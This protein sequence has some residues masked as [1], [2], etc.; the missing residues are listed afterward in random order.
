MPDI[1]YATVYRTLK[2]LVNVGLASERSFSENVTRFEPIHTNKHHDHMICIRCGKIMEFEN[3]KIERLQKETA[4]EY[5]FHIVSH[6]LEL[7]GYCQKCWN[8]ERLKEKKW[9]V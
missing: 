2:L 9:I 4:K 7:Y 8:K 5:K 6:K 3:P 1:G